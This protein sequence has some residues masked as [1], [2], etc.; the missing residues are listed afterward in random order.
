MFNEHSPLVKT[1]VRLVQENAYFR[2]DV[3]NL[4][5]LREIV[6]QIL[7]KAKHEEM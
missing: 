2:S 1:W 4:S 6:W 5:N 7:D 3:P